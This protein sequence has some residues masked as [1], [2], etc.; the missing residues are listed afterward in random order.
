MKTC[1]WLTRGIDTAATQATFTIS[2][3]PSL[4]A[5]RHCNSISHDFTKNPSFSAT[6][7]GLLHKCAGFCSRQRAICKS[8]TPDRLEMGGFIVYTPSHLAQ[9]PQVSEMSLNVPLKKHTNPKIWPTSPPPFSARSPSLGHPLKRGQERV[10]LFSVMQYSLLNFC[11]AI[12]Q[13]QF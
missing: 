2:P 6:V 8:A 11:M 3:N 13:T 5:L 9:S 4:T 7:N 12:Q 1:S 10:R